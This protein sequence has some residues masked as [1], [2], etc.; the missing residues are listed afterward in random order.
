MASDAQITESKSPI[1]IATEC[2][3]NC[4]K[5]IIPSKSKRTISNNYQWCYHRTCYGNVEIPSDSDLTVQWTIDIVKQ[6]NINSNICIGI[7]S[8]QD[9]NTSFYKNKTQPNYGYECTG[10]LFE[11]SEVKN[12]TKKY[13]MYDTVTMILHTT[14]GLLE[15]YTSHQD[16]TTQTDHKDTGDDENKLPQ[17]PVDDDKKEPIDDNKQES[18][19][20]NKQE[21]VVADSKPVHSF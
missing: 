2:F 21:S 20:N 10:K 17:E 6:K 13:G 9:T 3:S 11:S 14:S 15:F 4:H 5:D 7:D 16:K 19:D 18:V 12:S 1:T 8:S